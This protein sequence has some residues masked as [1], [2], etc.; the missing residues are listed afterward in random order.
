MR[1]TLEAPTLDLETSGSGNF[2]FP[3]AFTAIANGDGE[4]ESLRRGYPDLSGVSVVASVHEAA[5]HK[6][7]RNYVQIPVAKLAIYN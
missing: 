7:L 4:D 6:K 3:P 5:R 2:I 1:A